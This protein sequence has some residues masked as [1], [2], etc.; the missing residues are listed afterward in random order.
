MDKLIETQKGELI[1]TNDGATILKNLQVFHPAAK[2]LI[3]TSKAQDIEAGDGT[4]S[5]VI[6]AGALLEAAQ[7]LLEYGIHPTR[8][9]D[10]FALALNKSLEVISELGIK[11]DLS[12]D[13]QLLQ[14]VKTSLSSKIVSQ[15]ATEL[16]PIALSSIKS[17]CDI[18]TATNLDLND[19][20]IYQKLGGTLEDIQLFKG[21]L[22][23]DKM[24]L[25]APGAPLKIESP[26]VAMLQFCISSPKTNMENNVVISD[27]T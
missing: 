26:K 19:I 15:N 8:I 22:F 17:I 24:P 21:V 12:D 6:L 11:V 27:Y 23:A 2:L 9:S 4:T 3:Q 25:S 13:E 16:A 1:V 18:S 5:V 20:K 7:S 10:G 14:C